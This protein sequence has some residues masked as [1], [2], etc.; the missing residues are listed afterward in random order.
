MR[1]NVAELGGADHARKWMGLYFSEELYRGECLGLYDI[2]YHKPEGYVIR[3]EDRTVYYAFFD[4][5]AFDKEIELRGLTNDVEYEV[6]EYDTE[7]RRGKV[8]G[9]D[10]LFH[11]TS[12]P[13]NDQGEQVFY[14]V[15]KCIPL[16][17]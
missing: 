16:P 14:Y 15:L 12:K 17:F 11:I 2:E 3:K 6:I 9:A 13:G 10:P 8:V 7:T 5:K 1:W 4:E